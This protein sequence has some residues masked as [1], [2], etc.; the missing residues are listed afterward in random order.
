[1]AFT[2]PPLPYPTNGLE[3]LYDKATVEVHYGKH[4]AAYVEKLNAA[5][6]SAPSLAG[7]SVE[8]LLID[9]Q[10]L[11]ENVRQAIINN[12]GGHANHSLFWT[13]LGAG[14]G[15]EPSGKLADAIKKDFGSFT[16]FKETFTA[17]ATELF[18]SGWTFLTE[19]KGGKLKIVNLPNQDS[20]ISIGEKPILLCDLWEHAYYLK[21]QNRRAQWIETFWKLVDWAQVEQYFIEEPAWAAAH[22]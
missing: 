16:K 11:P 9:P 21:F 1:M 10:S 12:G 22:A 14:K 19:D 3:P 4:H 15:G 6:E 5:I 17:K 8:E 20:P 13:I 2:L 7:K 18:G